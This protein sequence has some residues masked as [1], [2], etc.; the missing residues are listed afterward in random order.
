MEN[1]LLK[2]RNIGFERQGRTILKDINL[3][4]HAG[5]IITLIGPNGAGKSTLLKLALGLIK[6]SHGKRSS[7]KH[8]R[9]GYMPQHISLPDTLPLTVKHFLQLA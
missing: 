3:D 9:I 6:P 8:L 7:N 2:L 1:P 4:I 5:E